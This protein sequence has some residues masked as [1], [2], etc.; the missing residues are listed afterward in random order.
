[1]L[2]LSFDEISLAVSDITGEQVE[3]A[4]TIRFYFVQKRI[5]MLQ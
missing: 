1:M 2:M 5:K 4:S 3:G